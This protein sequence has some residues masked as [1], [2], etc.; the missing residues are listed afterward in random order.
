MANLFL[1]Y[2]VKAINNAMNVSHLLLA[3]EGL[4]ALQRFGVAPATALEVINASS[5]RSLQTEV[6]LPERVLTGSFDYGF[7]LGLMAKDVGI[8]NAVM[9]AN[10]PEA[11]QFFRRSGDVLGDAVAQLGPDADYTAAVKVLEG[12]AGMELRDGGGGDNDRRTQTGGGEQKEAVLAGAGAAAVI[13]D[14]GQ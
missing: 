11:G 7:K 4:L 2:Q 13:D 1:P 6:R 5:G 12:V 14:G 8:A 3:S 9:D 10:F